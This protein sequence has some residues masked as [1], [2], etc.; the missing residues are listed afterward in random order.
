MLFIFL[1]GPL[2]VRDVVQA[3]ESKGLSL[4]NTSPQHVLSLQNGI[5]LME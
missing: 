2:F 1:A 5:V 4:P 3:G